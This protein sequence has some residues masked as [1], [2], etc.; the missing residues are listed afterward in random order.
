MKKLLYFL[1]FIFFL[2]V[3]CNYENKPRDKTLLSKERV[4]KEISGG[5]IDTL[6]INLEKDRFIFAS[7]FQMGIDVGVKIIDPQNKVLQEIDNL[8][9]GPEFISFTTV[10]TGNYK[11][12]IQAFNPMAKAGKYSL[13]IEINSHTSNTKDERVNQLFAEFNNDFRPGAAVAIVDSGNIVFKNG[14]GVSDFSNKELINSSTKLNICSIGKQFTAFAIALLEQ[15]GKLSIEDDIRNYLP[16]VHNFNSKISIQ[17]LLNHSGGLREIADILEISG[18]RSDGPFSKKDVMKLIY[19]QRELN[20]EPGSE[21]LYCNT[22]YILL[23]EIIEQITQKSYIEWITEN[24][25]K[26]LEMR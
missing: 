6:F 4:I 16:E 19:R 13:G 5:Q 26:P 25:F 24:I 17:H 20:F 1:G 8:K 11:I 14:F 23:A 10:E 15:E 3:G 22:G 9:I 12:L 18:K 21:H 7:L 2:I